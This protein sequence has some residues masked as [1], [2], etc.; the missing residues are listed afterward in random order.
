[1]NKVLVD[2]SVVLDIFTADPIFYDRSIALLSQ[3]GALCDL[4]IDEIVYAEVSAGFD[5]IEDLDRALQG[6]GFIHEPLPKEALFLATKAFLSYRKRG[7]VKTS[8][9]PDFFIGA[10]AAVSGMPLITR[11]ADRVR[12]AF[13]SVKIVLP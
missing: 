3:W 5:R 4:C 9:L 6:C 8:T 10:H 13:P 2:S 7:G 1:M 11:D 12:T